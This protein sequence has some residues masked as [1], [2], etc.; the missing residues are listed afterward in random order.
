MTSKNK[1]SFTH[2][3]NNKIILSQPIYLFKDHLSIIQESLVV[4]IFY[5]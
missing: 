2:F 3:T 5:Y 4:E 1:N